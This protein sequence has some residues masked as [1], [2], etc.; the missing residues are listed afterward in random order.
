VISASGTFSI[1]LLNAAS[2]PGVPTIGGA[3]YNGNTRRFQY[4]HR[5]GMDPSRFSKGMTGLIN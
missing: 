3:L 1:D 4:W 5:Y 2:A